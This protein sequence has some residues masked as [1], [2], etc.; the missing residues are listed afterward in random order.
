M[1]LLCLSSYN[2]TC[3][4]GLEP[5]TYVLYLLKSP[6]CKH[7]PIGG[8]GFN[9]RILEGHSLSITRGVEKSHCK[10]LTQDRRDGCAHFWTSSTT[11][12]HHWNNFH[13][14]QFPPSAWLALTGPHSA[15]CSSKWGLL[16]SHDHILPWMWASGVGSN[17]KAMAVVFY[18]FKFSHSA[19]HRESRNR[20]LWNE[21]TTQLILL[22]PKLTVTDQ[23]RCGT[24]A[25]CMLSVFHFFQ[26][27]GPLHVGRTQKMAQ[28]EPEGLGS[29]PRAATSSLWPWA[30]HLISPRPQFLHVT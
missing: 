21:S 5:H 24:W 14:S 17:L 13:P 26:L 25:V 27:F 30:R 9:V 2:D 29:G 4:I 12:L 10:R 1:D 20:C 15:L 7:S 16:S 19:L 28:R 11:L 23:A 6:I 18:I 8:W 22:F 3:S